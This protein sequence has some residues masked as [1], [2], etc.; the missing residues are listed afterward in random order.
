MKRFLTVT[1]TGIC[2][3]AT[4]F[5]SSPVKAANFTLSETRT[6][7][8]LFAG[9]SAFPLNT[10]TFNINSLA[11]N[12]L[13]FTFEWENLDISAGA[14]ERLDVDLVDQSGNIIKIFDEINV[15]ITG[16]FDSSRTESTTINLASLSAGLLQFQVYADDVNGINQSG[17]NGSMTLTISGI[18]TTET[19][20]EPPTI[21][22][23]VILGSV[24]TLKGLLRKK[25]PPS[26]QTIQR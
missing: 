24:G 7:D 19:V 10:F 13:N 23:L 21:L 16:A 2:V 25:C 4:L 17:S 9:A 3:V 11:S 18:D 20:P 14:P 6:E 22:G 26:K 5:L 15:P 8:D 1:A 12:T